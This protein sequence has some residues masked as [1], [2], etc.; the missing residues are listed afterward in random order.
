[1]GGGPLGPPTLEKLYGLYEA[2]MGALVDA[3][4]N[5][6]VSMEEYMAASQAQMARDKQLAALL[7]RK[8]EKPAAVVVLRRFKAIE[9]ALQAAGGDGE[10]ASAE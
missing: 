6:A 5:G 9:A 3:I 7:S 10:A 4:Q 2:R 8:G 1:M